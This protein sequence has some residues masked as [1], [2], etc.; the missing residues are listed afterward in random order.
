MSTTKTKEVLEKILKNKN[1]PLQEYKLKHTF[2]EKEWGFEIWFANNDMYCGKLLHVNK[3][4]RSSNGKMHYHKIKDE[5]FFII[6]GR[7]TLDFMED[8]KLVTL[9]LKKGDSF[10]I[11]PNTPHR[12]STGLFSCEFIEVSTHHD[13]SDSYYGI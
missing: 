1:S 4:S 10:R 5:T 6:K 7:L 8:D 13:D 12:F 3:L 11:K 9:K 2:V